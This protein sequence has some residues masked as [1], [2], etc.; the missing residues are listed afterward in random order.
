MLAGT[1][2]T[3]GG[4][5][6]QY[7]KWYEETVAALR[8][9]QQLDQHPDLAKQLNAEQRQRVGAAIMERLRILATGRL[10]AYLRHR[11]PDDNVNYSI[12]IYKLGDDEIAKSLGGPPVEILDTDDLAVD[13]TGAAACVSHRNAAEQTRQKLNNHVIRRI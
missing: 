1:Y 9:F 6:N 2:I 11:A 12:L 7:E 10:F 3:P 5:N 13:P 8:N 4:W